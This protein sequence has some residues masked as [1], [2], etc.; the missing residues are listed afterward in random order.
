[1]SYQKGTIVTKK[2][3][4]E[5]KG[6]FNPI[7]GLYLEAAY[8][9]GA[10][11]VAYPHI[12]TFKI[13]KDAKWYFFQGAATPLD[14]YS[15]GKIADDKY[16]T[17]LLL[18]EAGVPVSQSVVIRKQD[19]EDNN[20]DVSSLRFPVVAKPLA[21]T[22]KGNGV[23]TNIKTKKELERILADKFQRRKRVLV[24]EFQEDLIDYR[25]L[26]LD[27]KVIG[28]LERKA[29]YVIG[30]GA[31]TIRE[32]I[33][34]KNRERKAF[35]HAKLGKIAVNGK[36]LL[37]KLASQRLSLDSIPKKNAYVRLKNVCNLGAGGEV[38]DVTDAICKENKDIARKAAK[39]LNLRL[40]G[41]DFL[42]NDI[43]K[44]IDKTGG[45]VIE[46]N[47]HPDIAMHHFPQ[48]GKSRNVTKKI[49]KA[50]YK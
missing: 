15:H 29:A 7:S 21:G 2:N 9:L 42:C 50:F 5:V 37:R 48:A 22:V 46:V 17:N 4:E 41:F 30:D 33:G 39:A 32:L 13:Q 28:V 24:E 16:R 1:M 25:V 14:Q 19:F 40:A 6:Q 10:K 36:E 38:V 8:S 45:V 3:F 31:H 43:G 18:A 44:P 12:N 23:I 27:G 49:I 11:V 20:W 26:A 35:P 47:Q 34:L